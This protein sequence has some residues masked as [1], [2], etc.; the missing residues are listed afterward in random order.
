MK[1]M[2]LELADTVQAICQNKVGGFWGYFALWS[3]LKFIELK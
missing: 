3:L 2:Q 1:L